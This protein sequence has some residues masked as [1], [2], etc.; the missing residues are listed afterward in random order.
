MNSGNAPAAAK[1]P[2]NPLFMSLPMY[3]LLFA[4]FYFLVIA[5]QRKQAK[6]QQD[7][8]K[9]ISRGDEVITTSGIIGTVAGLTEKVVTLEVAPGTEIRMLRTQVQAK[10][11]ELQSIGA[12]T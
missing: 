10:L 7:F 1:P 11:N 4:L 9:G 2:V 5:P 8:Q 3:G 12:K 6:L